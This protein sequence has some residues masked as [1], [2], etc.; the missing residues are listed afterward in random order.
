MKRDMLAE[1]ERRVGLLLWTALALSQVCCLGGLK[2]LVA[3]W[4]RELMILNVLSSGLCSACK[5]VN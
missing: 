4:I 5:R 3:D 2:D 1:A